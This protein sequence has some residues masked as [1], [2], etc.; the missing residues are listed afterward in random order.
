MENILY[1]ASFNASQPNLKRY[2]ERKKEKEKEKKGKRRGESFARNA[3]QLALFIFFMER[4]I[5]YTWHL[6]TLANQM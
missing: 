4:K 5:F 3:A 2:G 1:L 6:S